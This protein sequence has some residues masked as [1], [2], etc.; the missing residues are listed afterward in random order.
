M[1]FRI[2]TLSR[3]DMRL[4]GAGP[5]LLADRCVPGA[6][7]EKGVGRSAMIQAHSSPRGGG[8]RAVIPPTATMRAAHWRGPAGAKR[9]RVRRDAGLTAAAWCRKV[10][11]QPRFPPAPRP[12]SRKPVE[13]RS[14]AHAQGAVQ[15]PRCAARATRFSSVS[16]RAEVT[17]K[18]S[19][20]RLSS[21]LPHRHEPW[22]AKPEP[23]LVH[24]NPTAIHRNALAIDLGQADSRC[25]P[26]AAETLGGRSPMSLGTAYSYRGPHTWQLR[27]RGTHRVASG[28]AAARRR[29]GDDGGR[30]EEL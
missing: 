29:A 26:I 28:E 15:S 2:L 27:S 17:R 4:T 18:A 7:A 20:D 11:A 14:R 3:R 5:Q 12:A 30:A 21:T 8:E 10:A 24:S 1:E 23:S 25:S 22:P 13:Q 19:R 6:A 16:S 9:R